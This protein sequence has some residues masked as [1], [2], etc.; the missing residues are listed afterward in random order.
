MRADPPATVGAR[1][2]PVPYHPTPRR[3]AAS[4]CAPP[5]AQRVAP[6]LPG[7][8]ARWLASRASSPSI[9]RT[10][11]WCRRAGDSTL[12]SVSLRMPCRSTRGR[13]RRRLSRR[14]TCGSIRAVRRQVLLA[15]R[16][17]RRP[18]RLLSSR[19]G[20]RR[21]RSELICH[22]RTPPRMR[23]RRRRARRTSPSTARIHEECR[24][25]YGGTPGS[26]SD[27]SPCGSTPSTDRRRL[28]G[29]RTRGSVRATRSSRI[30]RPG[31]SSRRS[32]E[33]ES[34]G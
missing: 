3:P 34:A 2:P 15:R 26:A 28:C 10:R 11:A 20:R 4:R 30:G 21:R 24:R 6:A 27:Q 18:R 14:R 5:P 31:T 19:R 23:G 8:R 9:L 22:Q 32:R 13:G 29:R 7:P 1:Q 25:A 33:G 17:P 12:G 16:L